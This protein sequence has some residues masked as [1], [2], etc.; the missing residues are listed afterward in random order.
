MAL[1]QKK[2][3]ESQTSQTADEEQG[4]NLR[5][6]ATEPNG[7]KEV[8]IDINSE[9]L[10]YD[11]ET[12]IYHA[13]G[14]VYMVVPEEN[15]EVLAD[16]A[17]YN[18]KTETLLAT[19]NVFILREGNVISSTKA[20]MD[21]T[22]DFSYYENPKTISQYF[23]MQAKGMK[24]IQ[25][26]TVIEKGRIILDRKM[27]KHVANSF[28][29]GRIAFGNGAQYSTFSAQ[30]ARKYLINSGLSLFEDINTKDDS[31]QLT[32]TDVNQGALEVENKTI[33]PKDVESADYSETG[34][35]FKIKIK[36]ADITKLKK[37]G[38][39]EIVFHKVVPKIGNIP[40]GYFP[41]ADIGIIEKNNY[42]A[43]L[44]PEFGYD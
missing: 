44:G 40:V 13:L 41:K 39:D 2:A 22:K 6:T 18:T 24:R 29:K 15:L 26:L 28:A 12:G 37:E 23:K 33:S 34:S 21:T 38:F 16:K 20:F 8:N 14:E 35:K 17:T 4:K 19:G 5:L 30:W 11:P 10:H 42:I 25:G 7:G 27:L 36:E 32:L 9:S 1:V 43:Y 3:D 31:E